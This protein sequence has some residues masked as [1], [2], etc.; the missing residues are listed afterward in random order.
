MERRVVITGIG[1]AAPGGVG[2]EEL[3]SR[4]HLGVSAAERLDELGDD[5]LSVQMGATVKNFDPADYLDRKQISRT[6]RCTQFALA[7]AELAY[8]DSELSIDPEASRR[9]G[10]FDGTSLGSINANLTQQRTMIEAPSARVSPS[11]LLKGMTGSSSGDV[12]LHFHLNGPSVTFSMGSVSSSYAIGYAYRK[13]KSNELDIAFAGGSEAPL[14]KEIIA[15]FSSAHL[16]STDNDNPANACKPFDLHRDGFVMG[17]GGATLILEELEQALK[18]GAH[19]YAEIAGF[20]ENTDAYHETTPEPE[21]MMI[22]EAMRSAM[23]EA[24]V[25]PC[26]VQYINAHGTATRFNDTAETKAIRRVFATCRKDLAI[27]STKPNTGHLLGACGALELAITSLA[28]Y[29]QWI[30][31]TLNLRD[32]EPDCTF[33]CVPGCGRSSVLTA[34]LSNNYSFGGRNASLLLKRFIQ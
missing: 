19:I 17:E 24:N 2:H 25:Q 5:R 4:I 14:S 26:D 27:S 16:L 9:A 8:H 10:V 28:L 18:R 7:S 22:A 33:D 29:D 12:A 13:I 21:G 1:V 23:H 34:A 15:L 32:P 6:E 31:P 11:V 3:W 30:P 20:G